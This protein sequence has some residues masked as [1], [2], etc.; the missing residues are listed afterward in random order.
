MFWNIHKTRYCIYG[1]YKHSFLPQSAFFSLIKLIS[2]VRHVVLLIN[3][4]TLCPED[5]PVLKNIKLQLFPVTK[6]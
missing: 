2:H 1:S 3:H 4:Q 5:F 6:H